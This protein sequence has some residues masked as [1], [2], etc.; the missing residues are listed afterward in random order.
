[1]EE[2]YKG[3]LST[4]TRNHD[5]QV[6]MLVHCLSQERGERFRLTRLLQ[7]A[8]RAQGLPEDE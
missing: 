3:V 6:E 4:A 2:F 1:M 8:R 5:A 7:E